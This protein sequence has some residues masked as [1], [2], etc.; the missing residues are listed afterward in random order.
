MVI[1]NASFDSLNYLYTSKYNYMDFSIDDNGLWVIYSTQFSNNTNVAKVWVAIIR[2]TTFIR[3]VSRFRLPFLPFLS[4][5]QQL[6][7]FSTVGTSASTI[8]RYTHLYPS[9]PYS[10]NYTILPETI[11]YT[12]TILEWFNLPSVFPC[13]RRCLSYDDR[14]AKCLSFAVFCMPS[15]RWL[16]GRPKSDSPS[17]CIAMPCWTTSICRL[18]IRSGE[19]QRWATTI[20]VR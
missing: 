5:I 9:F 13:V 3:H 8:T 12:I 2:F 14:W 16:T 4:W 20:A 17:I 7:R 18:P 19:R 15:I 1:S 6:C 11:K 10:T